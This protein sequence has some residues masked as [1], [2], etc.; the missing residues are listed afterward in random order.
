MIM[1]LRGKELYCK[2]ATCVY[3]TRRYVSPTRQFGGEFSLAAHE[4]HQAI[5]RRPDL[6]LACFG[7][8]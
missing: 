3:K 4:Q 5:I 6:R 2:W 7:C 8:A 1:I